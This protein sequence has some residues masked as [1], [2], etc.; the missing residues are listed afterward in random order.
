MFIK[1]SCLTRNKIIVYD[2]D[3]VIEMEE[4]DSQNYIFNSI[5]KC[6]ENKNTNVVQNIVKYLIY[7]GIESNGIEYWIYAY[8][9]EPSFI[10]YQKEIEKYLILV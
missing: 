6:Y 10:K 2:T 5:V 3:F 4:N 9:K 7:R 8:S 1:Y